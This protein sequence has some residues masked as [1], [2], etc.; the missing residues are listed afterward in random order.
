MS[1]S[2]SEREMIAEPG[3]WDGHGRGTI[4]K[5]PRKINSACSDW[6]Q[7]ELFYV[8]SPFLP[9]L[10]GGIVRGFGRAR[11]EFS[12][13]RHRGKSVVQLSQ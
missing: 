11:Q 4:K 13:E 10:K 9:G 2:Q 7:I 1:P 5:Q 8:P 6:L 3:L 12:I